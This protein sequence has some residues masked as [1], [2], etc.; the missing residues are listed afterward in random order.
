LGQ[1]N[2]A[3]MTA[4]APDFKNS[5]QPINLAD[6]LSCS[7]LQAWPNPLFLNRERDELSSKK[8]NC[9]PKVINLK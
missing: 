4:S 9:S 2:T 1:E 5:E 3:K 7:W 6:L 8:I